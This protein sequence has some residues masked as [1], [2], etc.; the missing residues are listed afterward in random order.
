MTLVKKFLKDAKELQDRQVRRK[1][2]AAPKTHGD[3]ESNW[4]VSYADMMTLLCGF[5]IML[6]SMAKLDDTKYEKAKEELS[7][8]FNGKYEAPASNEIA[9]FATQIIQEAG[10]EKN[11][12]IN[13]DPT[14]VTIAF[15]STV[16]FDK[17]SAEVR[18]EGQQVLDKLIDA[19]SNH[20]QKDGKQYR[21]VIEGHT[22]SRPITG[23]VF[24]SNWELSGARASR[25]VRM[26]L[27]KGFTPDRL[28]AIAY[29]DT[30]PVSESRRIDGSWD[31]E[32]LAKNRRV[33]LRV[34]EPKVDSIPIPEGDKSLTKTESAPAATAPTVA[35]PAAMTPATTAPAEAA[36]AATGLH[37]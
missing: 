25:V 17:L 14:G 3:D 12:V 16:F 36:P 9:K 8:Q 10:I 21:V 33:V 13:S 35:T 20:Q 32:A 22:D 18:N 34:L 31:E 28:T 19:I 2:E 27:Q 11:V 7:K 15:A 23:G 1:E 26:F 24:P 6:F 5:F 37:R 30:R 4:L 29:G